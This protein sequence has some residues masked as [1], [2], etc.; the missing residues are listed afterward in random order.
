MALKNEEER[1]SAKASPRQQHVSYKCGGG[2]YVDQIVYLLRY[3][4][5][6]RENGVGELDRSRIALAIYKIYIPTS[7]RPY[8]C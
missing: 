7:P 8:T 5:D 1:G 4:G 2:V 3:G 6:E